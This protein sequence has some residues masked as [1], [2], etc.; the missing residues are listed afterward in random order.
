MTVIV[1][2]GWFDNGN[3]E[4]LYAGNDIQTAKAVARESNRDEFELQVWVSG[5]QAGA[6]ESFDGVRWS[7]LFNRVEKIKQ[8]VEDLRSRLAGA[9]KELELLK[10]TSIFEEAM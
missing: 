7:V 2:N 3:A 9:E 1:L 5:T 4:T 8:E 6:Y 10:D